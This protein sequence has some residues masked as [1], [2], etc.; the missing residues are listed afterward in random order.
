[1]RSTRALGSGFLKGVGRLTNHE[2]GRLID[3]RG[4][5][6]CLEARLLEVFVDFFVALVCGVRGFLEGDL[7][8]G[9]VGFDTAL[10]RLIFS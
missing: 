7:V 4:M 6:S 2:R 3:R 9:L 1:M 10:I 5:V 8:D